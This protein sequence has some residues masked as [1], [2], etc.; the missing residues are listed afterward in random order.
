MRTAIEFVCARSILFQW[1]KLQS[2]SFLTH[3]FL[4]VHPSHA[5]HIR[6]RHA[7]RSNHNSSSRSTANPARATLPFG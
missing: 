7:L 3:F 2:V 1:E 6:R 5:S 4:D